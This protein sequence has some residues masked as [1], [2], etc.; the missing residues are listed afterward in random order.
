MIIGAGIVLFDANYYAFMEEFFTQ[1]DKDQKKFVTVYRNSEQ[2]GEDMC[3]LPYDPA[4]DLILSM[5]AYHYWSDQIK[6]SVPMDVTNLLTKL[7]VIYDQKLVQCQYMYFVYKCLQVF[8]HLH[9]E[10]NSK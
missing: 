7:G 6:T 3:G 10:Q 9:L 1:Y 5:G 2:V 8:V 4:Q